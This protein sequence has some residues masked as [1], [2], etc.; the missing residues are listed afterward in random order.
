MKNAL[1]PKLWPGGFDRSGAP[2]ICAENT[3]AV[4]ARRKARRAKRLAAAKP[5]PKTQQA[6]LNIIGQRRVF[7]FGRHFC[8]SDQD[9][10]YRS[11]QYDRELEAKAKAASCTI[12]TWRALQRSGLFVQVGRFPQDAC[13]NYCYVYAQKG[14][15]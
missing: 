8:F 3:A 4:E 6:L 14:A 5:L 7:D 15:K 10:S 2:R 1:D 11:G 13:G 9:G 12:T